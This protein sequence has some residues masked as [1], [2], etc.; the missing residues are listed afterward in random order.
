MVDRI[1]WESPKFLEENR[2]FK[3]RL[4]FINSIFSDKFDEQDII[5][6]CIQHK[7][8]FMLDSLEKETEKSLWNVKGVDP[9]KIMKY[10]D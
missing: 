5:G 8:N 9:I 10:L 3:T 4:L 1:D 6:R 7:L 2:N